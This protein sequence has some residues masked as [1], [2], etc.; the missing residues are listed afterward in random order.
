MECYKI[1]A[2]GEFVET[3]KKLAVYNSFDGT[4]FA[5]TY[6]ADASIL[7]KAIKAAEK[8]LPV[9]KNM[10]SYEK[11]S[12]LMEIA[13]EM[14][15]N[16]KHLAEVLA[17]EACKPM[18]Y[19]LGEIGRAIQTIIVAAEE[20]KR[21]QGEY[22]SIDWT[23]AGKGKEGWVKYFPVGLVAGIAPF[24]FPINLAVH[25]I[26]PAI[27]AGCPIILKPASSTPLSTLEF[28]RI[29][30]KTSLPKGALSVL[31]MDRQAGN[32]LV[33]DERFKLLTF[34]G[35]PEVGWKMKNDAGKKKVVLELGGN[36]GVIVSKT[37]DI[38]TAVAKCLMGGFAYSGQVCIHAQRIYVHA[39]IF[40]E[41][42]RKF[43]A[44][45][46]LLKQGDPMDAA[47]DVSAMIDEAN[48]IR[49]EEWV[50]EAIAAGAKILCG[51]KRKAAF[52]EP[53]VLTATHKNMKVCAL[54]VFGP[55]VTLESYHEFKD[56]VEYINDSRYGLQAGVFT[57][58]LDEMNISFSQLEV[59]GVIINDV[60]TFRVDHMPY[61][62]IKD[63]GLGREGVKY[64]I[65]DMMEAK[66]LVKPA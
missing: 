13:A 37:A 42:S 12:I 30:D 53:T 7:E 18:K 40:E 35:S 41:F 4:V 8:A 26:A 24:N 59:G 66:I 19:A 29:V 27:A 10:A 50:N 9:M 36:A 57:N 52:Y 58:A 33:T 39:D 2:G 56:A 31:P 55:V 5:E 6:L 15:R 48:A 64:A 22:L 21:L 44:A 43:A 51:G 38:D 32:Q 14:K 61:G 20:S 11:Y 16:E 60:P 47:T 17:M 23:P 1:Y 54:E 28:A 63:S 34:T 49:V 46:K 25:K 45:V 3:P 62:G 65:Y